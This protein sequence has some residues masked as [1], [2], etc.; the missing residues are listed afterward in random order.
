MVSVSEIPCITD[1][2]ADSKLIKSARQG[3][4]NDVAELLAAGILNCFYGKSGVRD[5]VFNL[6]VSIERVNV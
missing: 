5:N 1:V 3:V 4:D 2:G 6:F